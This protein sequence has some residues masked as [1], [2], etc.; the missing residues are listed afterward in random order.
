MAETKYPVHPLLK[1]LEAAGAGEG[2]VKLLG[3]FGG[4]AGE[5]AVR[6]YPSV[7]DLSIYYEVPAADIL[8][9]EAADP[10]ALPHGGSAIWV[11]AG[12][13]VQR[14]VTRRTSTQAGFLGGSIAARMAPGPAAPYRSAAGAPR[15]SE[16]YSLW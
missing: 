14:C 13:P 6:I 16:E 2:A 3:Y 4:D 12:A 9:V 11:R 5:G 8:H 15:E 1:K 7:D 10:T